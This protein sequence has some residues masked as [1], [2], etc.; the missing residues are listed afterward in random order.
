MI[1][2]IEKRAQ[3]LVARAQ[4]ELDYLESRG[5]DG[6][7]GEKG[8]REG[9]AR[10]MEVMMQKVKAKHPDWSEREKGFYEVKRGGLEVQGNGEG[11]DRDGDVEMRDVVDARP[12]RRTA[13][14]VKKEVSRE[15]RELVDDGVKE[16]EAYDGHARRT[17]E[18]YRGPLERMRR[19]SGAQVSFDLG[20]EGSGS[21]ANREGMGEREIRRM[22]TG[23]PSTRVVA[24]EPV[25]SPKSIEELTRRGSK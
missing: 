6:D 18:Y 2:R 19:K 14:V 4:S 17:V 24:R 16:L 11:G 12:R 23:M 13:T 20:S 9:L 5:E 1:S 10:E 25:M 21:R 7:A 3:G 8:G 15:L 22:S